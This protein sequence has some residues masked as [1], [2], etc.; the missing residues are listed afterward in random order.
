MPA[1]NVAQRTL[2]IMRVMH[3][4]L[5]LAAAAYVVLPIAFTSGT[6]P[7][8][9]FMVPAAFA[10]TALSTLGVAAFFRDRMIQPASEALRVNPDDVSAAARWRQGVLLSLVCCE[11]VALF[12]L[13]LRFIGASRNI[14][15]VFYTVGIFFLLAWRPRLELPTT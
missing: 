14:S 1:R 13:V 9:G 11:S 5:L 8:P 4:A 12:G 15:A 3:A 7:Q 6:M 2:Q 10:L